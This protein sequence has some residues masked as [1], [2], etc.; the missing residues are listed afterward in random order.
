MGYC[1]LHMHGV[2]VY[3]CAGTACCAVATLSMAALIRAAVSL[4][5][6]YKYGYSVSLGIISLPHC[7][8]ISVGA[9]YDE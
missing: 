9:R 6:R 3:V 2:R 8:S 4:C 5:T 1:T 7:L